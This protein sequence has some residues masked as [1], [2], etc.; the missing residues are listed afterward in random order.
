MLVVR[1]LLGAILGATVAYIG[2]T[3]IFTCREPAFGAVCAGGPPILA[4]AW[5][6]SIGSLVGLVAGFVLSKHLSAR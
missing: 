5:G 4:V 2:A 1:G 6:V 3:R